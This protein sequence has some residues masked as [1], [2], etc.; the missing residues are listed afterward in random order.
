LIFTGAAAK[1]KGR[2][3]G[4][5]RSVLTKLSV[6]GEGCA[7]P[8]AQSPSER[9]NLGRPEINISYLAAASKPMKLFRD[10]GFWKNGAQ[11]EAIR[12]KF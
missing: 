4:A 3:I 11:F 8:A 5:A 2:G 6:L 12:L 9:L 10:W 7:S 1:V